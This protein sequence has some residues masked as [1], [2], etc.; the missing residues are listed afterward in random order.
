MRDFCLE[1]GHSVIVLH[2]NGF[3]D[4]SQCPGGLYDYCVQGQVLVLVPSDWPHDDRKGV[5][6]RQ[7]CVTLNGFAEEICNE[8]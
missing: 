5:C 8:R 1:E 7:E 4:F 2:N 6:S 3:T